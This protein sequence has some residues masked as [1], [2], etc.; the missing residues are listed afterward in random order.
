MSLAPY[1]GTTSAAGSKLHVVQFDRSTSSGSTRHESA[2]SRETLSQN[3]LR[4][5]GR[6]RWIAYDA[7]HQAVDRLMNL[8]D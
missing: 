6:V 2:Q 4:R 7:I 5:V 1:V 8:A 3:V